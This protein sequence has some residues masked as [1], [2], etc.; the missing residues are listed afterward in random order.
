MLSISFNLFSVPAL[1]VSRSSL[2]AETDTDVRVFSH[3]DQ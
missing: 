3:P 1:K 2:Y